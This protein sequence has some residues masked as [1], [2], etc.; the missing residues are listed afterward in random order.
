MT[1]V[2]IIH[3]FD[4]SLSLALNIQN[5]T[6]STNSTNILSIFG[7]FNNLIIK[8]YRKIISNIALLDKPFR[9]HDYSNEFEPLHQLFEN[10]SN[11]LFICVDINSDSLEIIKHS[12]PECDYIKYD[13]I[14]ENE[15]ISKYPEYFN[16]SKNNNDIHSGRSSSSSLSSIQSP[17]IDSQITMNMNMNT[18]MNNTLFDNNISIIIPDSLYL[19]NYIGA[20]TLELLYKHKITHIINMTDLLE[21]YFEN[22]INPNDTPAFQYLKISIPDALHI[23]ITDYFDQTFTFI[24]N[25]LNIGGRVLIHCFAGKSRSASIV[26]GYLMKKE[27]ISFE[28]ALD[29]VRKSRPCVEPNLAFCT[30]LSQYNYLE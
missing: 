27:K 1:T 17:S 3:G 15:C 4:F 29:I 9:L 23:N 28:T 18:N 7:N 16:L 21:N 26:I 25:V 8:R 20:S 14:T 2:I 11:F 12:Y 19:T 24:D 13:T 6:D 5:T 10:N 22:T 30:Q